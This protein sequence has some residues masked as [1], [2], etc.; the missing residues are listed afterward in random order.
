LGD[1]IARRAKRIATVWIA[2]VSA[3][4]VWFC[5]G[6]RIKVF[7]LEHLENVPESADI[8]LL[9][10]HRSF[11]DLC[12]VMGVVFGRTSLPRRV[13]C[14][15]RADFFY[16]HPLG[17]CMNLFMC[18]MGMFPLILRDRER[19]AFNRYSVERIVN[20][21]S[22]P[23]TVVGMHPEGTRN[24][25]PDP[26]SFLPAQPG[27]G[28]ITLEARSARVFPVFVLGLTNSF[29]TE[30]KRNWFAVKDNPIRVLFG[31]EIDLSD[32]REE[33]SRPVTQK[34]AANRCLEAIEALSVQ[35]RALHDERTSR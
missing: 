8:I 9:A 4:I 11:F 34:K 29:F 13:F 23:G 33:G 6:R 1:F 26:Y 27:I 7:G 19:A 5:T 30:L 20:E 28:K 16:D 22:E 25:G 17:V 10:N 21:L 14:P 2:T 32:L 15:V 35:E 18:A 24:K 31:P 12:I 3:F